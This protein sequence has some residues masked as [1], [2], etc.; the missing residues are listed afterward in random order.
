LHGNYSGPAFGAV[1][2]IVAKEKPTSIPVSLYRKVSFRIHAQ[3]QTFVG[4]GGG[5]FE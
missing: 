3:G 4:H 5:S 2:G 1:T